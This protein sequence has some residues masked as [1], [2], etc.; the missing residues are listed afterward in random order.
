[1]LLIA[2]AGCRCQLL[3]F[4]QAALPAST[5]DP[6]CINHHGTSDSLSADKA[7]KKYQRSLLDSS[8]AEALWQTLNQYMEKEQP[9]LQA[10]LKMPELAVALGVLPNDLSQAINTISGQ[11]FYDFVNG[12]R[13]RQAQKLLLSPDYNEVTMLVIAMESGFASKATFYK[14]FKLHFSMTPAEYKKARDTGRGDNLS[15]V[16]N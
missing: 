2:I 11:S 8:T 7:D 12:F 9:F 10:G 15:T 1:F 5:L 16:V 14:Y 3:A 13:V 6:G 4:G